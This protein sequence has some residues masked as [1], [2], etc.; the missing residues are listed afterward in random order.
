MTF[1]ELFAVKQDLKVLPDA[2]GGFVIYGAGS[3]G[4][5]ICK[6][7]E[8]RKLNVKYFIDKD[9]QRINTISGRKVITP[10][11][12]VGMDKNGMCAIVGMFNGFINSAEFIEKLNAMGFKNILSFYELYRIMPEEFGDRY[13]MAPDEF[14]IKN[15]GVIIETE[16]MWGDRKSRELYFQVIAFRY[17]KEMKYSPEPAKKGFNYFPEDIPGWSFPRTFIDCGAFT[18]DTLL[19]IKKY[20]GGVK[21]A[22]AFEPDEDNF[23][24]MSENV[25]AADIA[26]LV[27]L[28]PC[29]VF[30]STRQLRFSANLGGGSFINNTG[31]KFIQTVSLDEALPAYKP[32]MI[33]MDI[34]GAEP[35]A[36]KGAEKMIKK[37]KPALAISVYHA[38]GHMWE[39]AKIISGWDLGYKFYLRAYGYHSFDVVLHAVRI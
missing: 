32:E 27:V 22:M 31:E 13:F 28:F 2:P 23:R 39:I 18:G 35:E 15:S 6:I 12:A 26:P 9:A 30:S 8:N 1:E 33:K 24:K 5:D 38:P 4:Q 29:G 17:T 21:S 25:A 19:D 14:F 3:A 11:A 34:E 7:L 10:E 36:L 37:H 16:K 20:S